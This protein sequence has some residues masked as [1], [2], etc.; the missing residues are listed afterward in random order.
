[1]KRPPMPDRVGTHTQ[2][3]TLPN[4]FGFDINSAENGERS[5]SVQ[6]RGVGAEIGDSSLNNQ[7]RR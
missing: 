1:M 2:D 3:T 5:S 6:T 4:A 7:S